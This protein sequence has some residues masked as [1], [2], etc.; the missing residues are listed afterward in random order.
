MTPKE[1]RALVLDALQ[2]VA[3]DLDSS[4]LEGKAHLQDD[5]QLDSLDFLKFVEILSDGT[6]RRIEEDDY[7]RFATIDGCVDQLAGP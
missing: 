7:P 2:Q 5:L 4:S 3:P 6:G 1:A